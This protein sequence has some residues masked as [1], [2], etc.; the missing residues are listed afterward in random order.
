MR[1]SDPWRL[2]LINALI[3]TSFYVGIEIVSLL[4]YP[5][6][7]GFLVISAIVLLLF[8]LFIFHFTLEKFI[9]ARIRIIYKLIRRQ[10]DPRSLR[11]KNKEPL[12][13][14]NVE[15]EVEQWTAHHREEIEELR[16]MAA[17]RREFM[18]NVSH[19]LKTPIFNIQ[20][21]VLTLLDGGLDDVSINR[22]YLL[23]TEKS[24][25]R[26][27]AIVED[28]EAI[29]KLEAGEVKLNIVT[30]DIVQ[31]SREVL[32]MLEP[33]AT[34]MGIHLFLN[35]QNGKPVLV[36]ADRE[37][38]RQVITNLLD[39][40]IKYAA[41]NGRTKISFYDVDESILV[42][43]A[44]NGIGIEEHNLPR[45]FERFYRTDKARSRDEGGSGLG[46]AIVKHII[47]AHQQT[48]NVRSTVGL[49]TTFGFTL[50]KS[51]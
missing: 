15:K 51:R 49:G 21:Y 7:P 14:E 37:K 5:V 36:E 40:S 29:S 9:Y 19:E 41:E 4:F 22:D 46:L 27:I 20:G 1:Q 13:L 16:R 10:K 44:D 50:K 3:V 32:E 30:F 45:L 47:E 34:R 35:Y 11:K 23:R 25:N 48:V 12:L 17:Y 28:L 24:I 6:K 31:L 39:N 26:L 42:E 8:C 33:K 43:V 2:A 38:I 18:G